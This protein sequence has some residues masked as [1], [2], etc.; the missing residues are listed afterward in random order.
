MAQVRV[1]LQQPWV[2][3]K[4][5]S[6]KKRM[7]FEA[8]VVPD[9]EA[10]YRSAKVIPGAPIWL[11]LHPDEGRNVV[12]IPEEWAKVYFGDWTAIDSEDDNGPQFRIVRG[13]RGNMREKIPT[14]AEVKDSVAFNWGDY[15][16]KSERGMKQDHPDFPTGGAIGPPAVPHVLIESV[17][18]DGSPDGK[19]V[20][21]PWEF[22]GFNSDFDTLE[23]GI[24]AV[25]VIFDYAKVK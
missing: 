22:L 21:D 14:K 20:Y 19:L 17:G 18:P 25:R 8:A 5:G 10:S 3:S 9:G 12:L 6:I 13:P 23:E 4:D 24:P 11:E 2:G 1:T 7:G 16:R 15:L